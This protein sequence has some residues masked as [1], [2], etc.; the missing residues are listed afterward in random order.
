MK[1]AFLLFLS[2]LALV[3]LFAVGVS[4]EEPTIQYLVNEN[5]SSYNNNDTSVTGFALASQTD[6]IASGQV[7]VSTFESEKCMMYK[8]TLNETNRA[9]YT[10][11]T[12]QIPKNSEFVYEVTFWYTGS[13]DDV[14]S[15]F[16][17]VSG[18][19][20]LDDGTGPK[21]VLFLKVDNGTL[22]DSDGNLI[23]ALAPNTKYSVAISVHDNSKTFDVYLN[24][25]KKSTCNFNN[26]EGDYYT[27][28]RGINLTGMK[29]DSENPEFPVFYADDFKLYYATA[30]GVAGGT[31]PTEGQPT[32]PDE[33]T[34]PTDPDPDTG[35]NDSSSPNLPKYEKDDFVFTA[36][37]SSSGSSSVKNTFEETGKDALIAFA[38][39]GAS[40]LIIIFSLLSK[41]F[42]SRE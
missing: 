19:K 15:S 14:S 16:E 27:S 11:V 12:Y 42:L 32:D 31:P 33:P 36:T 4:A 17:F 6:G 38:F 29:S 41:K 25:Q 2:V 40:V 22:V 13:F 35:D 23:T 34:E 9:H 3:S 30:P 26:T 28:I 18:R 5:F 39:G 7:C 37:P 21:F 20:M 1:K 8:K 24:G 10:D